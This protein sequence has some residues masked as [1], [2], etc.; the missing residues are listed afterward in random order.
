MRHMAG[1][2][3]AT[4]GSLANTAASNWAVLSHNHASDSTRT[5]NSAISLAVGDEN[6]RGEQ[7][8]FGAGETV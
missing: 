3:T 8:R 4:E 6:A 5:A 2:F 7:A 1:N